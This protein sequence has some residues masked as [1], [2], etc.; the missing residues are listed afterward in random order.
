MSLLPIGFRVRLAPDVRVSGGGTVLTG[1]APL[2]VLFPGA[3]ARA[4]LENREFSVTDRRSRALADKLLGYGIAEPVTASLPPVSP[5]QV[6]Y[7]VPVRDRPAALER[8]LHSIGSGK[9]VVVVDDASQD[10]DTIAE[11]AARHGADYLP[12]AENGGPAGARNAGLSRVLTPFVVFA[13]SD[14]VLDPETVPQLLRHFADPL[15]ALAAPRILGW[16]PGA[17]RGWIYRY[18][19]S[20]SSLDLGARSSLVHP[21]A[22]VSWLPAAC[23]VGRV[24][25]LG[26]GFSPEL[27]VA[28][29]VDLVWALVRDGWRVR[30]DASVAARHEHR[31]ELVP[32]L[33]RKAFYGTGAHELALRHGSNVAPA[34]FSPWSAAAM[35]ALLAQRRWSVPAAAALAGWTTLRL[36]GR[37]RRGPQ[38]VVLAASLTGQ[39]ML[40]ALGQTSALLLRHWWPLTAVG[41]CVSRR[42]RRAALAAALADVVVEYV[43]TGTEL[44]IVRFAVARRLDDLAYGAGVWLGAV[45]GRSLRALKPEITGRRT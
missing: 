31:R 14:M 11:V 40:A 39:G 45:R 28:E 43:R 23:L 17:D 36:A 29:D 7:V 10:P 22:P 30:Y 24:E 3:A 41:V 21:R 4:L 18:E 8:L 38:P 33:G 35:L 42:I 20:R 5:A 34:V 15:V 26:S 19:D 27:R 44:D 12:L 9:A 25:A 37:L 16:N 1:G 13:D 2:R 6:T 32:W